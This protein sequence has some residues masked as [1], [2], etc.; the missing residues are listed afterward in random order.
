M[1]RQALTVVVTHFGRPPLWMPAFLVS[2]RGNPDVRWI[3]YTDMDAD[4]PVP[5]N[6]DIVPTRIE[7]LNR[8]ASAALGVPVDVQPSY[9]KKLSDLKPAYGLIFADDLE[10]CDFWAY[11]ELDVIWGDVRRFITDDLLA[12]H[13]IVSVRH[14]KLTG[15]FTLFRNTADVNRAFEMIPDAV[16][17]IAGP[18]HSRLD[19][20]LFTRQLRERML[21]TPDLSFPRVHW[22]DDLTMTAAYQYALGDS[23]RLWWR[24]GRTFDAHGKELVC[25]HFHKLKKGMTTMDFGFDAAPAAFAVSRAGIQS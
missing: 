9:L 18:L 13:D 14:Y 21:R 20:R 12:R 3:I 2:C 17:S 23:D 16:A 24:G 1:A 5:P 25:L 19:E 10:D 7:D 4:F 11:S 22:P 15:H 6:V 8:R